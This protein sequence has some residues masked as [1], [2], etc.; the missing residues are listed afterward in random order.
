VQN[1][2]WSPAYSLR[3][4]LNI[5]IEEVIELVDESGEKCLQSFRPERSNHVSFFRSLNGELS[6]V[7]LR[8]L[9]L[10][11]LLES[12][13]NVPRRRKNS[14]PVESKPLS[15]THTMALEISAICEGWSVEAIRHLIILSWKAHLAGVPRGETLDSLYKTY[16]LPKKSGGTRTITAPDPLLKEFQRSLLVFFSKEMELE[17][18]V[19][20]F[21][22]GHSILTNATPHVGKKLVVNID[23][24]NFFPSVPYELV[25]R[26]INKVMRGK[27]SRASTRFL[28]EACCYQAALPTGAPT[29]PALGNLVLDQVD[30]AVQ[31]ACVRH[32]ITYTR[33]ADDLTFSGTGETKRIIPFVIKCLADLG[34]QIDP[35]KLNLYRRGRRQIVTGLVVNDRVNLPRR[36]RKLLRAAVHRAATGLQPT[37]HGKPISDRVLLGHISHLKGIDPLSASLLRNKLLGTEAKLDLD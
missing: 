11:P 28:S 6:L 15:K 29:S 23:V 26:A 21:R 19:H 35:K 10:C 30:R 8:A 33:Y 34:L 2:T 13:I 37:W 16:S 22:K 1:E 5:S 9:E 20:G 36:T 4:N 25:F 27:I 14:K 18:C 17:G 24:R 12:Y 31:A 32:D 7:R 3:D